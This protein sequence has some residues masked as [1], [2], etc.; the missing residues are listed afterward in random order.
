MDQIQDDFDFISQSLQSDSSEV[1]NQQEHKVEYAPTEEQV[2]KPKEKA[3]RIST[4]NR[5]N[6]SVLPRKKKGHKDVDEKRVEKKPGAERIPCCIT[7]SKRVYKRLKFFSTVNERNIS[8][9]LE[10]GALLVMKGFDMQNAQIEG[11][12]NVIKGF[13]AQK[14]L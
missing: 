2:V 14:V 6:F 12:L 4:T 3:E 8:D 13:D 5:A 10:E 11:L 7:I 9:I 1:S